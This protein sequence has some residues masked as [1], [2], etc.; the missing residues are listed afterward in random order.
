MGADSSVL[1]EKF[2]GECQECGEKN[3]NKENVVIKAFS[4]HSKP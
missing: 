1:S 2:C 4:F 3:E